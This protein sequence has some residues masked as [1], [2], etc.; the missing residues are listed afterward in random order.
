[1]PY[2]HTPFLV[3]PDLPAERTGE[4]FLAANELNEPSR[5][6]HLPEGRFNLVCV[7][8]ERAWQAM[9]RHKSRI[10][11]MTGVDR[12]P[13]VYLYNLLQMRLVRNSRDREDYAALRGLAVDGN[14]EALRRRLDLDAAQLS[15]SQRDF[16]DQHLDQMVAS[17]V[18][19]HRQPVMRAFDNGRYAPAGA[20]DQTAWPLMDSA[21]RYV[22]NDDAF[23]AVK[24]MVDEERVT[25]ALDSIDN[26]AP[27]CRQWRNPDLPA[28][29]DTSNASGFGQL[30]PHYGLPPGWHDRTRVIGT[31]KAD[32]RDYRSWRS[33]SFP[34]TSAAEGVALT[35]AQT[36]GFQAIMG[37]PPR[38]NPTDEL[39]RAFSNL[40][41]KPVGLELR[42][43]GS[44]PIPLPDGQ[45]Y[46]ASSPQACLHFIGQ[47][48]NG[49]LRHE[50]ASILEPSRLSVARPMVSSSD[51][52]A[53]NMLTIG[54]PSRACRTAFLRA[55]GDHADNMHVRSS[56]D[57][58]TVHL[59][60]MRAPL[61]LGLNPK[62]GLT[63]SA[64]AAA[65]W[66]ATPGVRLDAVRALMGLPPTP[67]PLGFNL[68]PGT[69]NSIDVA[70]PPGPGHWSQYLDTT[71]FNRS[72]AAVGHTPRRQAAG[73][74]L[75]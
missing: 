3:A 32:S 13:A 25:F 73:P 29:I 5:E 26:L 50:A 14:T 1:M 60:M 68:Q 28:V 71:G 62:G 54:F 19:A 18:T 39:N 2:L 35:Q 69:A 66:K 36:Q 40:P 4:P 21:V 67:V 49:Q 61:V 45:T 24:Q 10:D 20:P 33:Y 51:P 16:F 12:D 41:G 70:R 56:L 22:D 7:G 74:S 17:F 6:P 47:I 42:H 52:E 43:H 38:G 59:P 75:A 65:V 57:A 34:A 9:A 64:L 30:A 63:A 23:T 55:L 72:T 15:P 58:H 44:Q 31:F 8:G 48:T 37:H 46:P 11:S 27:Y 53:S